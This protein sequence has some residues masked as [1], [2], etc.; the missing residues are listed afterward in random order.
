MPAEQAV[1]EAM[2]AT[3]VEE[4][5][6]QQTVPPAPESEMLG[7]NEETEMPQDMELEGV[8][9]LIFPNHR[10]YRRALKNRITRERRNNDDLED[11]G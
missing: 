5:A 7:F 10:H 4:S 3:A 9:S 11:L 1:K 2:L 8:A 6:E